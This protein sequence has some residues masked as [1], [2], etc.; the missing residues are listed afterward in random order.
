M[1]KRQPPYINNEI[2]V[3]GIY[4]EP[5]NMLQVLGSVE[6][7][8]EDRLDT[9]ALVHPAEILNSSAGVNIH[10]GSGQEHLTAIRSPVLTGG[11]GAGSFLYLE[12]GVPLRAAGFANVNGLFEGGT[13]FAGALE[14]FKGPGPAL[15]GSN[16][17]HGLINIQ[18]KPVEG[19]SNFRVLGSDDGLI[20]T[21]ASIQIGQNVR[22]SGSFVSDNGFREDSGFEQQK[23]Q[24]KYEGELGAWSVNWLTSVNNL[25][26]ETAG[27]IEGEDAYL[28]S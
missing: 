24:L 22:A 12:D 19:A 21:Q 2:I 26:Q 10:R 27:F 3:E 7:L 16:A 5:R 25:N 14:V 13:E 8:D 4:D 18:S 17:V 6:V 23:I 1:Y 11:S 20:S 28:M 9:T 15:Y